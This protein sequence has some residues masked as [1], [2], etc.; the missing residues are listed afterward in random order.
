LTLYTKLGFHKEQG[1][2]VDRYTTMV[3]GHQKSFLQ[4]L[5]ASKGP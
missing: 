2:D 5:V 4:A 1:G 3:L